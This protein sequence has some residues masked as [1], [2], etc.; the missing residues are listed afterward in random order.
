MR[1][2]EGVGSRALFSLSMVGACSWRGRLCL[3]RCRDREFVLNI[4]LFCLYTRV[5]THKLLGFLI[6]AQVWDGHL[7]NWKN[8]DR[9]KRGIS[10]DR[11]FA[12][13]TFVYIYAGLRVSMIWANCL[14]PCNMS[15][16]FETSRRCDDNQE[17]SV[18]NKWLSR[19]GHLCIVERTVI[20][21]TAPFRVTRRQC[22][23]EGTKNESRRDVVSS[24]NARG[25]KLGSQEQTLRCRRGWD[26]SRIEIH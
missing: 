6:W 15:F 10:V 16:F 14:F 4:S 7:E 8:S 25:S 2:W 23:Q 5:H 26:C 18:C 3:G 24:T 22:T 11:I 12:Q 19:R 13:S 17:T 21:V 20:N 9:S 1:G